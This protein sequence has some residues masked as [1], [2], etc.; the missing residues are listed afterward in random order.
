MN[1][2]RTKNLPR[3]YLAYE[4]FIREEFTLEEFTGEEFTRDEFTVNP[5]HAY[6]WYPVYYPL[7]G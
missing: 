4:V 7:A 5:L 3:E 6:L 2:I 1:I